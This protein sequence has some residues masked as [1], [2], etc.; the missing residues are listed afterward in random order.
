[1][2][3]NSTRLGINSKL[4]LLKSTKKNIILK[5]IMKTNCYFIVDDF[6]LLYFIFVRILNV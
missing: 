2:K 6:K 3:N 5:L 4:R 1:M